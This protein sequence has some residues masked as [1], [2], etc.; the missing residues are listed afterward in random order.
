MTKIAINRCYGGF[1]LSHVGYVE[2]AKRKGI[3]LHAYDGMSAIKDNKAI[4]ADNPDE[5]FFVHYT[6]KPVETEEEM[7]EYYWS[8]DRDSARDDPDLIAVIEAMGERANG[9]CAKLTIV[10]IPDGIEWTVEEYDG[11]E[12]IAEKH[13]TWM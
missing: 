12:W 1:S 4:P 10:E 9:R 2:F 8:Q 13:R 11:L 5:A 6:T 7:N 3:T